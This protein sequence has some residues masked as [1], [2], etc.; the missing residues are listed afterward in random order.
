MA[1]R[2]LERWSIRTSLDYWCCDMCGHVAAATKD[3]TD[4]AGQHPKPKQLPAPPFMPVTSHRRRA[5]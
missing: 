3:L 5:S 1:L 4:V 2:L